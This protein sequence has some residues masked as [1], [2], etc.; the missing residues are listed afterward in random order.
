[1]ARKPVYVTRAKGNDLIDRSDAE[2]FDELG[3]S[4]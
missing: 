1:M 4:M 3:R 2:E